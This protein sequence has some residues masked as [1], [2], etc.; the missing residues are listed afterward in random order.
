MGKTLTNGILF[1]K[2]ANFFPCQIFPMYDNCYGDLATAFYN[3]R[4]V[5]YANNSL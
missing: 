1:A 2:F 5:V 3:F 4:A